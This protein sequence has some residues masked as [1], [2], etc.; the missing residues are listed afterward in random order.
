MERQPP[1]DFWNLTPADIPVGIPEGLLHIYYVDEQGH[2][3]KPAS[4][5][6][7][8][9]LEYRYDPLGSGTTYG[10]AAGQEFSTL[11]DKLSQARAAQE[12]TVAEDD[13]PEAAELAAMQGAQ[14]R[15]LHLLT[16][17]SLQNF[18][19]DTL[20][21]F[22]RLQEAATKGSQAQIEATISNMKLLTQQSTKLLETQLAAAQLTKERM[23]ELQPTTPPPSFDLAG[24]LGS[25][26][27]FVQSVWHGEPM[28]PEVGGAGLPPRL[29]PASRPSDRDIVEVEPF[30]ARRGSSADRVDGRAQ[31]TVGVIREMLDPASLERLVTEPAALEQFL[32]RMRTA[33]APASGTKPA[34]D[35][36]PQQ[37][38]ETSLV[39]RTD[40]PLRRPETMDFSSRQTEDG[41]SLAE[42]IAEI[43]RTPRA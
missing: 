33:A 10:T 13:E 15:Q 25:V 6:Q 17:D 16:M 7:R 11:A 39:P 31:A 40:A 8:L 34:T 5:Q 14:E 35:G 20:S 21:H 1:E 27:P 43:T 26:L 3:M 36:A 41:P 22:V 38:A 9:V 4:P 23:E 12:S 2:Y 18:L 32:Q 28:R 29:R 30:S 24:V 19:R 42:L 37:P